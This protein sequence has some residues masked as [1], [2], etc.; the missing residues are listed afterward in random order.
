MGSSI[1]IGKNISI[2]L[3]TASTFNFECITCKVCQI[4]NL[5]AQVINY[6]RFKAFKSN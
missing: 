1:L 6:A 3:E 4:W 2:I 5:E